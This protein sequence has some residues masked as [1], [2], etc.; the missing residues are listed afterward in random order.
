MKQEEFTVLVVDDD[1]MTR[2]VIAER[3]RDEGGTDLGRQIR[4]LDP[5]AIMFL[6]AGASEEVRLEALACG[7][8][9][10]LEKPFDL[11]KLAHLVKREA[12]RAR[13][14]ERS[15]EGQGPQVNTGA[16]G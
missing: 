1:P 12:R 4:G 10:V 15:R 16:H 3:L 13:S 5:A 2:H 8:V 11:S 14:A 6:F 7:V 9:E